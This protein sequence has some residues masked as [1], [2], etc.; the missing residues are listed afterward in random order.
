MT[1]TVVRTLSVALGLAALLAL[2][3]AATQPAS[4]CARSTPAVDAGAPSAQGLAEVLGTTPA[5]RRMSGWVDCAVC[6]PG[7]NHPN[8]QCVRQCAHY[9]LCEDQCYADADTCQLADCICLLC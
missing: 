5:P 6:G 9:G 2:L 7:P 1:K 3:A 8:L 4:S